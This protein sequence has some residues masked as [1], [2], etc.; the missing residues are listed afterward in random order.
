MLTALHIQNYALIESV[1]IRFDKGFTVITGETGAGKSILMGALAL[2]LGSRADTSMLFDKSR[3]CVV[4]ACFNVADLDLKAFFEEND[5]DYD[6]ETLLRREITENGKSRAFIND[7][8]VNLSVLRT[9]S[10]RLVD[11]HS[12]HQNLLLKDSHFRLEIV[13]AYAQNESLLCQYAK[14]FAEYKKTE[15]Q[16]ASLL[17]EQQR[18]EEERD[19]LQFTLS[20]LE[21][22]KLTAGE[23]ERLEEEIGFLAN[24][25]HIKEN[26]Y[27]AHCRL[28][29]GEQN[30]LSDLQSLKNICQEIAQYDRQIG[31]FVS[32]LE[33]VQIEL[34][35]LASEIERK[36]QQADIDPA[37][38]TEAQDRL[39]QIYTLED[40][41]HVHTVEALLQKQQE[42]ADRLVHFSSN[43]EL[44]ERLAQERE[45][46][47]GALC[48]KAQELSQRRKGIAEELEKELLAKLS[49]LGM[50]DARLS[51][52]FEELEQPAA[53]G[54]DRVAF[55]FAANKGSEMTEISK[56]A[57]GGE[58]SRVMLAVKS[59]IDSRAYL[60]TIIFD[61]IDT[62][63][64]GE[65]AAKTARVM[66]EIARHRQLLVITHLPQI[67][68]KAQLHYFVYK[69]VEN[70]RAKTQIRELSYAERECEIAKMMSGEPIT[71]AA[72]KTASELLKK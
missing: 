16:Y 3:K 36:E 64:S 26:L 68:A 48:Q 25:Q 62:G 42:V 46:R 14:L 20:E 35:D 50:A 54:T 8:P 71:E 59:V 19:F 70:E 47:Y 38:L 6:V 65:V 58:I 39:S 31:D 45:E 63:I 28:S 52:I 34:K 21:E 33:S 61:E 5:L 11:I 22:A 66:T 18:N 67:A 12:Q 32:R 37:R 60:P 15:A 53:E 56:V 49:L 41:Y 9:L 44:L 24:A 13:D 10:A 23:Q 72:R 55:M 17:A 27:T 1:N 29:A 7:T 4:E 2:L 43:R 69:T 51:I 40:K 30:T 57:S